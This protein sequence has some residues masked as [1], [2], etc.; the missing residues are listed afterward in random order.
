[1]IIGFPYIPSPRG[2][3]A[4]VRG[5]KENGKANVVFITF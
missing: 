5:I 4:R 1:V 2:E 3:R